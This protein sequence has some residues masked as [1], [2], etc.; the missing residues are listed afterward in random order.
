MIRW[1]DGAAL[2]AGGRI[3]RYAPDVAAMIGLEIALLALTLIMFA[4]FDLFV[5]ACERI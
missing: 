2:R 3:T 4:L 1:A 5:R